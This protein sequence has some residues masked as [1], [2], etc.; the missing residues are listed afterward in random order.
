MP[1]ITP[2]QRF[3]LAWIVLS[4]DTPPEFCKNPRGRVEV[5]GH[6]L[7]AAQKLSD[8][9]LITLIEHPKTSG[10]PRI[11]EAHPTTEGRKLVRRYEPPKPLQRT[12]LWMVKPPQMTTIVRFVRKHLP[13]ITVKIDQLGFYSTDRKYAGSRLRIPGQGRY[14]KIYTFTDTRAG[15]VHENNRADPNQR[16]RDT[17]RWLQERIKQGKKS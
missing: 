13:H 10:H 8:A 1:D 16:V 15:L 2:N 14:G 17:V 5:D 9:R 3:I 11:V 7:R 6:R 12:E 4:C